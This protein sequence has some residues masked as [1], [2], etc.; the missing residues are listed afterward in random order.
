MIRRKNLDGDEKMGYGETKVV[1]QR[2]ALLL[3]V[4]CPKAAHASELENATEIS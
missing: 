4:E 1:E 3:E 2:H